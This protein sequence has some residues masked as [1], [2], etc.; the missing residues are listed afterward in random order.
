MTKK[1]HCPRWGGACSLQKNSKEVEH[2]KKLKKH[3]F[4]WK[5]ILHTNLFGS[6]K[7]IVITDLMVTFT[8]KVLKKNK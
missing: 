6:I 7:K 4:F 2:I 8:S 1:N 5:N 3:D